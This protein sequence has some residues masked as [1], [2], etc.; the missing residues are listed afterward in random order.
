MKVTVKLFAVLKE[1]LGPSVT[2]DLPAT[3]SQGQLK[4]AV[5][6]L[7]PT[8]EATLANCRVAVDQEF[9]NED[10]LN[11]SDDSEVALIPPVSG[12]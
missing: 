10:V 6:K 11:L 8:L 7:D 1:H 2:I 12:G 4:E 9:V 5:V 3:L